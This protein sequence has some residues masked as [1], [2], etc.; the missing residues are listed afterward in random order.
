MSLFWKVFGLVFFAELGDKTQFLMIAM[1]SHYRLR[2]ILIGVSMAIVLLN[3]LAIA[4]GILLGGMLPTAFIGIVAG[5]AFLWFAY[6]SV[7][8]S[9]GIHAEHDALVPRKKAA[10]FQIFGT[11]FL[12]ELGDKTQ[13]TALTF[14]ADHGGEGWMTS[15]LLIILCASSL[16]LL[17]ADALGLLVGFFLGRALPDRVFAWISFCIFFAFGI[18]KLLGGLEHAVGRSGNGHWI[19][20]VGTSIIALLFAGLTFFRILKLSKRRDTIYGNTKNTEK[21]QSLSLL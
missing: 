12:A 2:D 8:N 5:L 4:V 14:A 17:C 11:F 16:A 1:A 3:G 7:G 9:D 19:P 13:L 20:I 10:I 21:R 18:V 15:E 6:D